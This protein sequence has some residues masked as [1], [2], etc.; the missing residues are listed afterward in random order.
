[1]DVN[2]LQKDLVMDS[3]VLPERLE[4]KKCAKSA[5]I[6]ISVH[7]QLLYLF[8]PVLIQF[9]CCIISQLINKC[10]FILSFIHAKAKQRIDVI[11]MQRDSCKA[12]D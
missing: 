12:V 10:L 2:L 4:I 6:A 1:M 7:Q 9:S 3:K 11:F 8:I 5:A